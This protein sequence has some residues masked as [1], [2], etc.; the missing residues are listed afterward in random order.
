MEL[1]IENG[2]LNGDEGSLR[3]PKDDEI[4]H[5]LAMLIEG[6]CEGLGPKQAADKFGYSQQRYF[7]IREAFL[8]HGAAALANKKRGPKSNY[9]RT[10]EVERQ[11]CVDQH[12]PE[13]VP[14]GISAVT[15]AGSLPLGDRIAYKNYPYGIRLHRKGLQNSEE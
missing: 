13:P 15:A 2:I 9:R 10:D 8:Q 14:E 11:A 5:K 4:T 1:D 7:Q 6:E 12:L 3:V